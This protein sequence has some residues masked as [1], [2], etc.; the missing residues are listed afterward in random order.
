MGAAAAPLDPLPLSETLPLPL[1][2][3]V[4]A[5]KPAAANHSLYI[6]EP[7]VDHCGFFGGEFAS[8]SGRYVI[9]CCVS[10]C[11]PLVGC[12]KGGR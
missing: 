11:F 6:F 3:A 2:S 7:D 1:P 4:A 9:G 10:H 8:P 12:E 5:E